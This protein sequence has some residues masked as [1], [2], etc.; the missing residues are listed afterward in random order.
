MLRIALSIGGVFATLLIW[1]QGVRSHGAGWD[2]YWPA[3]PVFA[4]VTG[5]SYIA[6]NLPQLRHDRAVQTVDWLALKVKIVEYERQLEAMNAPAAPIT[7]TVDI[8]PNAQRLYRWVAWWTDALEY[9]HYAT[10][11]RPRECY[12]GAALVYP[13]EGEPERARAEQ[14]EM[15]LK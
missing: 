5:L 13:V 14:A 2:E 12:C 1:W 9:I 11:C 4:L 10:D 7:Q 3:L 15:E 6:L 8:D